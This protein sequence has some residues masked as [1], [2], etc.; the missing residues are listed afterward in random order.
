MK[1]Q[2]WIATLNLIAILAL[3]LMITTRASASE[4]TVCIQ[5]TTAEACRQ[6]IEKFDD[7][8]VEARRVKQQRDEVSGARNE[9]RLLYFDVLAD[10]HDWQVKAEAAQAALEKSP[11]RLVWFGAG[12]A[13]GITT[14][15]IVFVLVR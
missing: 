9:L 5:R 15:V 7:L 6:S 13:A 1:L 10:S 14:T 11:S 12:A 4:G 2:R 3:G 8:E